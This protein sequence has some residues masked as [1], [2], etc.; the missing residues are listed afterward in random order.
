MDEDERLEEEPV[1]DDEIRKPPG[2]ALGP[3]S[4]LAWHKGL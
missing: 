4:S 3:R 1:G 2:I